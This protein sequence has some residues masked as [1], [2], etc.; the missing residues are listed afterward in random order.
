MD[1]ETMIQ[2]YPTSVYSGWHL[3]SKLRSHVG[4]FPGEPSAAD[5]TAFFQ[6]AKEHRSNA[7]YDETIHSEGERREDVTLRREAAAKWREE[8]L[9]AFLLAHP[10]FKR[11]AEM[12]LRVAMDYIGLGESQKAQRELTTIVSDH[13]GSVASERAAEYLALLRNDP[14]TRVVSD[15]R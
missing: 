2:K 5:P 4:G 7:L 14:S 6:A 9:E 8:R 3:W 11:A 15:G 1:E 13:A 10:N 12:R